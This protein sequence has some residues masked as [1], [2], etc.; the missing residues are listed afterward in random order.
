M[1]I[2]LLTTMAPPK[3]LLADRAYDADSLR[4]WLKQARIKAVV[5]SSAARRTPYLSTVLDDYSRYIIAWKLCST[6]RAQD[7][8][9]T[10]DMALAASG[11]DQAHV[12][13]RPRL[14]SDN[15]PS[16]IAQDL[17]DYIRAN[18]MDH[19][20]GAPMHRKREGYPV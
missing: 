16:Y 17:A 20:R 18:G 15:G 8:T 6:M 4:N 3:R 14:L 19:V 13:H 9:D 10:L 5:P 7:V 11:C 1:A 2:P 12:Q